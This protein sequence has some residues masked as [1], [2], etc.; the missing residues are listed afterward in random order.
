L[1]QEEATLS[2]AREIVDLLIATASSRYVAGATDQAAVLRAQLER[3]RLGEQLADLHTQRRIA[4]LVLNQLTS[5]PP[6]TPVSRVRELPDLGPLPPVVAGAS[7]P[8]VGAKNAPEVA[9][10]L[11]AI[12]VAGRQV[13]SARQELHS[14]LTV[15][16]GLYWQGGFNRMAVITVGVD[17]P[18][19][20]AQ[21]QQP[22]LLAA[23][24]ELRA[25]KADL[26]ATAND[27]RADVA[28]LVAEWQLADEQLARYRTAILP[29]TSAVFDATRSSYL[30]GRGDFTAVA[31]EFRRWIEARVQVAEREAARYSA[32]ARLD[33]ILTPPEH[34]MWGQPGAPGEPGGHVTVAKER[35]P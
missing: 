25:A 5:D 9:V 23:E 7:L 6:D 26:E 1:D 11:S 18:F 32:R 12:E 21:K 14:S 4:A 3:T 2:D 19:W 28:T 24:H 27:T 20:K 16:A 30:A 33:I 34:G 10:R 17:L 8:D 15:G 22:M 13:E 31:E 35:Q 29:Q